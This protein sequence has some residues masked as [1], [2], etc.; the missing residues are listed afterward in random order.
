MTSRRMAILGAGPVGLAALARAREQGWDARVYE[1]GRVG[2]N[3]RAWGH[4][5]MFSPHGMNA[6]GGVTGAGAPGPDD[7][8]T[9]DEYVE[10]YLEPMSRRAG[11]IERV[12]T[13][14]AVLAVSRGGLRKGDEI[15]TRERGLRP[16]HVLVEG[17]AGERVEEA[18]VVLDATGTFGTPNWLGEGGIPAPGERAAGAGVEHALPDLEG[19]ARGLYSGRHTLVVGS[20]H[21]AATAIGWLARIARGSPGTRVTWVTRSAASRPVAEVPVDPLTERARV[22][23]EANDMAAA[24]GR[25]EAPWLARL[26]GF[27][28]RG[29][30]RAGEGFRAR[31]SR[32]A[33]ERTLAA[34]RLLALVGYRPDLELTRELQVQTC[35]ATE[36]TYPL[37]AALLSLE[38]AA[39]GDCLR[40]PDLGSGTLLHPER[41]FFTVGAK[42]YGRNPNFLIRSGLRQ[43]DEVLELL[44][45]HA[46]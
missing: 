19:V 2:E 14:T 39:A 7:L 1:R 30:E 36:G 15:A 8:L 46:A 10:A 35:W 43:V 40:V 17:P 21:S 31:L 23:A 33:E 41:G 16:F 32:G 29:V 27:A 6:G 13:G 20:G 37:A 26:P 42:S 25:G 18:E 24:A 5:R 11:L 45:G 28:V 4:V 3:V 38:G 12:M 44:R 34:D 22:A 9:G